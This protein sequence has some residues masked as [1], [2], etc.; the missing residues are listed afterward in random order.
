MNVVLPGLKDRR[1]A[2][3]GEEHGPW[4]K[5]ELIKEGSTICDNTSNGYRNARRVTDIDTLLLQCGPRIAKQPEALD[6]PTAHFVVTAAGDIHYTL[7]IAMLI[8]SQPCTSI[9]LEFQSVGAGGLPIAGKPNM[10][11]LSREAI[12]AGRRLVSYFSSSLPSLKYICQS[13]EMD[14]MVDAGL[15]DR[16]TV[17]DLWVNIG[18]WAIAKLSLEGGRQVC[19]LNAEKNLGKCDEAPPWLG[20]ALTGG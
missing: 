15:V 16:S 17:Q 20:S 11:S 6:S 12:I 19:L 3:K 4:P 10:P 14:A 2:V 18:A 8:Q 13:Q 9:C 5:E 7:D 1:V